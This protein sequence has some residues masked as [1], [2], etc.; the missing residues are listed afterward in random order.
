M[1]IT[2][3]TDSAFRISLSGRQPGVGVRQEG[4]PATSK[5]AVQGVKGP[6]RVSLSSTARQLAR[7]LAAGEAPSIE[8]EADRMPAPAIPENNLANHKTL[9][10]LE[11]LSNAVLQPEKTTA[12]LETPPSAPN[13]KPGSR[14]NIRA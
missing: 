13:R 6:D 4:H 9:P 11:R 12:T 8:T 2:S 3:S 10:Q 14:I 1:P 7:Q 5:D